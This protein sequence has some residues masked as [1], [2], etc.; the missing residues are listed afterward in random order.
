MVAVAR[1]LVLGLLTLSGVGVLAGCGDED[2]RADE[3]DGSEAVVVHGSAD[4]ARLLTRM[5]PPVPI[6]AVPVPLDRLGESAPADGIVLTEDHLFPA[7]PEEGFARSGLVA[8]DRIVL[9]VDADAPDRP[10][11]VSDLGPDDPIAIATGDG[12]TATAVRA[13][14]ERPQSEDGRRLARRPQD[15]V[16]ST[17]RA[18]EEVAAGRADAAVVLHSDLTPA[19]RRR[20]GLA[21][22]GIVDDDELYVQVAVGRGS[23]DDARRDELLRW[24]TGTPGRRAF[25]QAGFEPPPP[26]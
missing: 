23:A 22:V 16:P 24:L 15:A 4:L 5:D 18:L 13:L 12:R 17:E 26:Q 19:V 14:L 11:S 21:E 6:R 7:L 25:E 1:C 3:R 8:Q 10:R 2:S 20:S 9:A